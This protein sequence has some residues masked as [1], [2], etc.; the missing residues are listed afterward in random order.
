M[1]KIKILALMLVLAMILSTVVACGSNTSQGEN[2]TGSE[3]ITQPSTE[4]TKAPETT[5]AA[6]SATQEASTSDEKVVFSEKKLD[7]SKYPI[8]EET[9]TMLI[10]K[11]TNLELVKGQEFDTNSLNFKDDELSARYVVE[12]ILAAAMFAR[13][14]NSGILKCSLR[15]IEIYKVESKDT[16][17]LFYF[18]AVVKKS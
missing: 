9:K 2:E 14:D 16:C 7:Y 8:S 4:E 17:M 1:R 12:D 3:S 15:R 18:K 10:E 11:L 6:E 13:I 5:T